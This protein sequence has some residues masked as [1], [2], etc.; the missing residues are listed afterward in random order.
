MPTRPVVSLAFAFIIAGCDTQPRAFD[1]KS[2][3]C[4]A[5]PLSASCDGPSEMVKSAL[6][7]NYT[8]GYLFKEWGQ[9]HCSP[10]EVLPWVMKG[11]SSFGLTNA[12]DM[13][14]HFFLNWDATKGLGSL[15][16]V[17][18]NNV[19]LTE[20]M[21]GPWHVLYNTAP[22][23]ADINPKHGEGSF[24]EV[25]IPPYGIWIYAR[26]ERPDYP[27]GVMVVTFDSIVPYPENGICGGRQ[28]FVVSM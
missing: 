21:D 7:G 16:M 12:G 24:L 3:I 14:I 1:N 11:E 8:T 17:T 23:S 18:P 6:S 15:T 28:Q 10:L 26:G 9:Y 5:N 25:T 4:A 2:D 20:A 13:A 22:A 27:N 19:N